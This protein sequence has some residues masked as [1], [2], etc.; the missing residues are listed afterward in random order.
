[1][2]SNSQTEV[3][4]FDDRLRGLSNTLHLHNVGVKA[5]LELSDGSM[6]IVGGGDR[7]YKTFLVEPLHQSLWYIMLFPLATARKSRLFVNWASN[8]EFWISCPPNDRR[9]M[10]DALESATI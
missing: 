10:F 6:A 1:M 2:L 5:G 7:R 8:K 9:T 4:D 3:W